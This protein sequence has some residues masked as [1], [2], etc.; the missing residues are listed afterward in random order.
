MSDLKSA[1]LDAKYIDMIDLGDFVV[2][3]TGLPD[4]DSDGNLM[5][6]ATEIAAAIFR[7]AA[8]M[9]A[10]EAARAEQADPAPETSGPEAAKEYDEQG[11]PRT[12]APTA[13]KLEAELH[14]LAQEQG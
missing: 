5:P 7:W 4:V 6:Q 12:D 8:D 11:D 3:D 10:A 13:A 9:Q 1:I 2:R 14:K